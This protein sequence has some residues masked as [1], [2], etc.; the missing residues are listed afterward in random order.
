M[1]HG[2]YTQ[3][4]GHALVSHVSSPFLLAR[5]G[6]A[7]LVRSGEPNTLSGISK[8]NAAK[9]FPAQTRDKLTD[10][11]LEQARLTVVIRFGK[12]RRSR[13]NQAGLFRRALLGLDTRYL[14]FSFISWNDLLGREL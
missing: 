12:F 6:K 2:L 14:F 8:E 1:R 13:Q 4:S 10:R 5:V 3:E 7:N 11:S 9:T